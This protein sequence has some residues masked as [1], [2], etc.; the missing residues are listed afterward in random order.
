MDCC[1]KNSNNND[2][3]IKK[4]QA[5]A[6]A[7]MPVNPGL[8]KGYVSPAVPLAPFDEWYI[9]T[10]TYIK[11]CGMYIHSVHVYARYVYVYIESNEWSDEWYSPTSYLSTCKSC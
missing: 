3:N 5:A 4:K 6:A 11:S 7:A 2:E 1:K 10:H 8:G 9:Y